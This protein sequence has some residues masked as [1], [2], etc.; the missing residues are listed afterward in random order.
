MQ[1]RA[2]LVGEEEFMWTK[3]V[4]RR[5]NRNHNRGKAVG[6]YYGYSRWENKKITRAAEAARV[7]DGST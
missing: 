7:S 4:R 1:K 2:S 5:G 6:G 3:T